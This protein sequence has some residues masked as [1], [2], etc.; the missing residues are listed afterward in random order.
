MT[1]SDKAYWKLV[2]TLQA[3]NG[4]NDVEDARIALSKYNLMGKRMTDLKLEKYFIENWSFIPTCYEQD[5]WLK[6]IGDVKTKETI[7]EAKKFFSDNEGLIISIHQE[8]NRVK[9]FSDTKSAEYHEEVVKQKLLS[10]ASIQ[11]RRQLSQK[12]LM[13][14]LNPILISHPTKMTPQDM[15]EFYSRNVKQESIIPP[16]P[17]KPPKRDQRPSIL[18]PTKEKENKKKPK[19]DVNEMETTF[20]KFKAS[21]WKSP[22]KVRDFINRSNIDPI[23]VENQAW[24]IGTN[25][26][27][28][29]KQKKFMKHMYGPRHTFIIDYF[30]PGKFMYLLAININ[31][32]KVFFS[33]PKEVKKLGN[34]RWSV[35]LKP[36][37]T[38]ESAIQSI[39]DLMKQTTIKYLIMDQ[40]PAWQHQFHQFLNS[41]GIQWR[42]YIKNHIN[43]LIETNEDSRGNHST[44][45][46]IDRVI[47]TIRKMNYNL[48]NDLSIDP[49]TLKYLIDEYNNSPH[50]TLTKYLGRKTTPNEVDR[51][52][53]F[54]D[55]IVLKIMT[56]NFAVSADPEFHPKG[57]VRIFNE[58]SPFDKLKPKLLPGYW[59]VIDYKDGL[60]TC[61]QG[62][63]V[64][65]VSR[66]MIKQI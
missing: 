33:V 61:K 57:K 27:D 15:Y 66:W 13:S 64:I 39:E 65:K 58:S 9:S 44:T 48:G 18:N 41:K 25:S 56:E 17:L 42:H 46:L 4:V 22:S 51:N 45:A 52:P 59:D 47:S 49:V 8:F 29:K 21:P 31:T 60:F 14:E 30:F 20:T 6:V 37:P 53:F 1:N 32:R 55:Q 12:E 50:S 28:L 38:T 26:F 36:K 10:E 23:N 35:P 7:A 19:P 40:E 54:E 2:N 3:L 16:S 63:Y 34:G 5:L 24:N 11:R 62:D 43:G